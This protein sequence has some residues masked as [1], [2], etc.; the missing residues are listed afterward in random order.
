MLPEETTTAAH[1]GC[2][3]F[4]KVRVDLQSL[5]RAN[6]MGARFI[7]VLLGDGPSLFIP[8]AHDFNR[9]YRFTLFVTA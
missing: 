7:V 4:T 9:I 3:E 2:R 1:V 8:P 6:G 5:I